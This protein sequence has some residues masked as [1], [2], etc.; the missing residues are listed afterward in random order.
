M[1][2]ATFVLS[3]HY[4]T[5]KY[6]SSLLLLSK[7]KGFLVLFLAASVRK[8]CYSFW[9]GDVR[10]CHFQTGSSIMTVCVFCKDYLLNLLFCTT[11][12]CSS[13]ELW[14]GVALTVQFLLLWR[15]GEKP[16]DGPKGG[17]AAFLHGRWRLWLRL[18]GRST[19]ALFIGGF[20]LSDTVCIS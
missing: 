12:H 11:P 18:V 1:H 9:L 16:G 7:E 6:L 17:K 14:A 5:M 13:A 2:A 10:H 19:W 4:K 15:Q 3:G 20:P 8:V